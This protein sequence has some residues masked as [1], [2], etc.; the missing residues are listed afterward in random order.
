MAELT[1]AVLSSMR[2]ILDYLE[3]DE[4]THMEEMESSGQDTST[5][6]YNNIKTVRAFL[7]DIE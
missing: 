5:H 3:D 6:I 4:R 1:D 2:T 7:D